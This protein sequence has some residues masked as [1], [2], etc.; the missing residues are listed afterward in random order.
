[1]MQGYLQSKGTSVTQYKLRNS[2]PCIAPEAHIQ[3]QTGGHTR[4]NPRHYIARYFGH[5]LHVDQN[6]K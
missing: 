6:E 4:S 5:K 3:R 1:M 2:L